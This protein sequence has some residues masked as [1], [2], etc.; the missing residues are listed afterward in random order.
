MH[1]TLYICRSEA[2]K[3]IFRLCHRVKN[4]PT[5]EFGLEWMFCLPFYNL[6]TESIT[7]FE[8]VSVMGNSK[9]DERWK[10]VQSNLHLD[11]VRKKY[12]DSN[13]R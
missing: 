5:S 8:D 4:E 2:A 1:L 10:K 11:L 9:L 13:A 3:A 6:L 12:F 7:P